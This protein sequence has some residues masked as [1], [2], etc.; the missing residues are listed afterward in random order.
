MLFS[1]RMA[2]NEDDGGTVPG[3]PGRADLLMRGQERASCHGGRRHLTHAS[4]LWRKG[5]ANRDVV[6][7]MPS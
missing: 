5:R 4:Q 6:P 7:S 1:I 2:G 3:A